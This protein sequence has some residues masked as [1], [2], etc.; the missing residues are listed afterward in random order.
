MLL[1]PPER[2]TCSLF[3]YFIRTCCQIQSSFPMLRWAAL[4]Q[5]AVTTASFLDGASLRQLIGQYHLTTL[6]IYAI[7]QTYFRHSQ[8]S[9]H[10]QPTE[11][12]KQNP[13]DHF[14]DVNQLISVLCVCAIL[15][16]PVSGQT[17]LTAWK[18]KRF[19][20][21]YTG[22]LHPRVSLQIRVSWRYYC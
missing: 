2:K 20:E 1:P 15:G 10:A 22:E 3:E 8:V 18:S 16:V 11:Y 5:L 12:H 17:P 7:L 9:K 14:L 4:G 13:V 19:F 6:E 21:L